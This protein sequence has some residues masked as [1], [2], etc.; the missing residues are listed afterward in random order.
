[1]P[2]EIFPLIQKNEAKKAEEEIKKRIEN[3]NR[4]AEVVIGLLKK[5]DLSLEDANYMLETVSNKI[6]Q[7][8]K[9]VKITPLL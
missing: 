8:I 4:I 7:K 1:M 5:E 6:Q 2:K 9:V 3:I